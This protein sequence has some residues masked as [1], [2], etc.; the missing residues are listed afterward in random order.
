M[1]KI[2]TALA[3]FVATCCACTAVEHPWAGKRIAFL[4][5]SITDPGTLKGCTLY[6]GFL[7]EWLGITPLVYGRGGHQ[8]SN[9]PGQMERLQND[10]GDNLDAIMV[11]IG[12]NDFNAGIPIGEWFT[13]EQA[14]VNVDGVMVER[15]RRV[16]CFDPSTY[17]GRINIALD[18]LKKAYPTKQIVLLTPVHRGP[19]SFGDDNVQPTEDFQNGCGEYLDAYIDSIKEAS[20]I[21]SVPVIDTYSLSGIMPSK[22]EHSIYVPG[23]NDF[24]HPNEEGHRRLA[25]CIYYQLQALPCEF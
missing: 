2:L 17:R 23:K 11:F 7:E 22:Q 8:W 16:T 24:L 21:W 3:L 10:H 14:A 13:E 9:I 18:G 12:T 6:W 1:K 5:D 25:K 19:A 4:G 15:T 20:A